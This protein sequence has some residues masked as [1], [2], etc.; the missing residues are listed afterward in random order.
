MSI[1]SATTHS[2]RHQ[3]QVGARHLLHA[4]RTK[5]T[6]SR[7]IAIDVSVKGG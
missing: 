4:R 1:I 5:I 3:N 2:A 7:G 6:S